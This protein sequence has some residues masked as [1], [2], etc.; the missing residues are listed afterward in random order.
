MGNASRHGSPRVHQG[1]ETRSHFKSALINKIMTEKWILLVFED[2]IFP[3]E[4]I[5]YAIK[6]AER[7]DCSISMLMLKTNEDETS[8]DEI[9]ERERIQKIVDKMKA[10][11]VMARGEV[12]YGDKASEFIKHLTSIPTL[13]T[14]VWGGREGILPD[15]GKKKADRWFLK[16]KSNVRCPVVRPSL[17]S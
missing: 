8:Q 7:I 15:D 1:W 11:G 10:K 6:L 13:T 2:G 12:C 16:V 3:E 14:I 4:S 9:L 17:R 5:C